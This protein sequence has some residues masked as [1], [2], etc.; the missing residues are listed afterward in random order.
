MYTT[1][2]VQLYSVHDISQMHV[3]AYI[4]VHVQCIW[5]VMCSICVCSSTCVLLR[6]LSL[7]HSMYYAQDFPCVHAKCNLEVGAMCTIHAHWVLLPLLQ[8][9]VDVV[10]EGR[11]DRQLSLHQRSVSF[12]WLLHC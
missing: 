2:L 5:N 7:C 9:G 12:R 4:H 6:T 10:A 3:A 11:E 1:L 8:C